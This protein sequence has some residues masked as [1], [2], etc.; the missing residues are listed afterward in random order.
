ME[1]EAGNLIGEITALKVELDKKSEAVE[2]GKVKPDLKFSCTNCDK[3]CSD[4][5]QMRNHAV[6]HQEEKANQTVKAIPF[7]HI[8]TLSL[9]IMWI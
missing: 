6:E 7:A 2:P 1:E 3:L 5:S 8:V 9:A 4:L